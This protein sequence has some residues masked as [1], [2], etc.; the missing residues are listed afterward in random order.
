MLGII[1]IFILREE[2]KLKMKYIGHSGKEIIERILSPGEAEQTTQDQGLKK[3]SVT[4]RVAR[5][6]IDLAYG[7]FTPLQGFMGIAD[8]KSICEKMTLKNGTLWPIPIIFDIDCEE[9]KEKGIKEKDTILL[10]Y[11]DHAL[12]ILEIEEIFNYSKQ[13]TR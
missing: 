6:C 1:L 4:D 10:T 12:A 9:I 8:V 2:R 13:P 7:F 5:E 3:V 11:N